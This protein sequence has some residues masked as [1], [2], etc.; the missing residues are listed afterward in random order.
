MRMAERWRLLGNGEGKHEKMEPESQSGVNFFKF[1][2]RSQE[3]WELR[4]G[5]W[6]KRV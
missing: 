3:R 1:D 2:C 5:L 6:V 4:L